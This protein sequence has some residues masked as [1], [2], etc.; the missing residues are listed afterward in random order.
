MI[1]KNLIYI[2]QSENY[3]FKRFLRFAYSRLDWWRLE[4]RKKIVWTPKARLI[5][6]VSVIIFSFFGAYFLVKYGLLGLLVILLMILFLPF[7]VGLSLIIIKPLDI[8]LKARKIK[9][10]KSKATVESNVA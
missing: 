4:K 6:I 9:K 5:N 2:L 1:L 7:L 10:A 8:I 3:D